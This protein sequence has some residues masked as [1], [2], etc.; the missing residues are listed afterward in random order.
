MKSVCISSLSSVSIYKYI[1]PPGEQWCQIWPSISSDLHQ[2]SQISPIWWQTGPIE[3]TSVI[4]PGEK[5]KQV[6]SAT[7]SKSDKSVMW[8]RLFQINFWLVDFI[9]LHIIV[10]IYRVS[11]NLYISPNQ[12]LITTSL[13]FT[14]LHMSVTCK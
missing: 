3:G 7:Y 13:G 10:H 9:R 8:L 14:Q 2:M 12:Q 4:P 5:Q 11:F 6:T 1:R